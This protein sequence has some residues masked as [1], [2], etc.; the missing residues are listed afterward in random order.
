MVNNTDEVS[1]HNDKMRSAKKIYD[2]VKI[3][4]TKFN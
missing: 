1:T 3:K 4:V 2:D